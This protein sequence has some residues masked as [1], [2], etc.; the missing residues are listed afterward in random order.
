MMTLIRRALSI[1]IGSAVLAALGAGIF[2]SLKFIAT[3]VRGFDEQMTIITVA[4]VTA[5]LVASI[6][7][8]AIRSLGDSRKAGQFFV[9][10]AAAYQNLI[11]FWEGI[12]RHGLSTDT[13]AVIEL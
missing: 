11:L 9:Q 5:L 2:F 6:I 10:K 3:R 12:R 1:S 4:S 13:S 7:G 8:S